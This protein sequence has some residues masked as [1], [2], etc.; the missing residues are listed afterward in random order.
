MAAA[1]RAGSGVAVGGGFGV[2]YY[3]EGEEL[4][5]AE[6]AEDCDTVLE[7]RLGICEATADAPYDPLFG[8]LFA[9]NFEPDPTLIGDTV[10]PN[11]YF[12][13]VPGNRW[14]YEGG[15]E[16]ITVQV[17]DQTK[18]IDGITCLT[19]N[20]VVTEDGVL[21]E[22]TDDWYAQ[23][24]DGDIW[25][26]GEIAQNYELFDGDDPEVAELVDIEGSWKHG[27]DGAEAGLLLPF[28]PQA[29]STIRQEV[30][31]GE[32]EDVIEVLSTTASQATTGTTVFSCTSTCLQTL[33]YTPLE[34]EVVEQKFYAPGIGLIVELNPDTL[35][36]LE[37]VEFTPAP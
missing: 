13:L 23:T 9:A 17:L 21:I 37:L 29:G 28:E 27:R 4:D 18:L 20:D 19:V 5:V 14:V 3:E 7:A 35:E 32:A 30:R 31:Y 2:S 8:A 33:D 10:E 36:R 25:Y 22:N 11:P 16:T 1:G 26:C 24:L 15:G 34:P 6:I 12:P